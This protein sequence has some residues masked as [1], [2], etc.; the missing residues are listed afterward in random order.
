MLEAEEKQ[1]LKDRLQQLDAACSY[2]EMV[3]ALEALPEIDLEL[4]LILVRAYL[5]LHSQTEEDLCL[6]RA[7]DILNTFEDEGGS[8]ALYLYLKAMCLIKENLLQDARMR[9]ERALRFVPVTTPE[10]FGRIQQQLSLIERAAG[11]RRLN[12]EESAAFDLHCALYFGRVHARVQGDNLEIVVFEP[13]A[14]HDYYLLVTKGLSS[15][16]QTVPAGADPRDNSC[17]ELAMALPKSWPVERSELQYYYPFRLLFDLASQV[18]LS[19]NFVGFGYCVDYGRPLLPELKISGVMLTALGAYQKIAQSFVLN[20]G[21]RVNI[22]QVLP[23]YPLEL[24]YRQDHSA[25]QLLERLQNAGA[26]LSP[27]YE[28]RRD[29]LLS[30]DMQ[31]AVD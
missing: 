1:S 29:A 27:Y 16:R 18:R 13:N 30:V 11:Q 20:D 12:A 7:E 23:L 10:L 24:A 3:D 26:V 19:P 2:R 14:E 5:N 21:F 28:D 31:L 8:D 22:F 25:E 15:R 9:L 4:A 6:Q 17:L